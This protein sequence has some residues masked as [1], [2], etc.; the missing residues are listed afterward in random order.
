MEQI[1]QT[2]T[3]TETYAMINIVI[4]LAQLFVSVV[5]VWL[6]FTGWRVLLEIQR[7]VRRR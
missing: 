6:L 1:Q 4:N 7:E 2:A 3:N 5:M